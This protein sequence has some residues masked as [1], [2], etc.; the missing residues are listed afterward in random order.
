MQ[1]NIYTDGASRGNPGE[2]G[3]GIVIYD[4]DMKVLA[5]KSEYIGKT[6]NNVAEYKAA[7]VALKLAAAL[8]ASEVTLYADSQLLVRQLTGE[9]KVKSEGLIP[10]YL[11]VK[12]LSM[13]FKSFAPY[14]VPRTNNKVADKLA[15]KAIDEYQLGLRK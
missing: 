4:Q 3:I 1:V 8:K 11:Q 15:N 12:K 14:H 6:T 7:I 10:L 9:Y 2:A 13:Q 5:E